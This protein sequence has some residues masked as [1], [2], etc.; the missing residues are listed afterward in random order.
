M[1]KTRLK[2]LDNKKYKTYGKTKDYF[3]LIEAF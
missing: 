1:I 2:T 3:K